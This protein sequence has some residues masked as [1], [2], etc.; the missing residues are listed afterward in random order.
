MKS[1]ITRFLSAG[2]LVTGAALGIHAAGPALGSGPVAEIPVTATA[3]PLNTADRAADRVGRLRFLGAL[4]LTSSD[5]RF[6]GLSDLRWEGKCQRLLAVS[7]TG[8]W[9]V[10]EP[11]LNFFMNLLKIS[12]NILNQRDCLQV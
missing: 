6:G 4:V 2:A 12:N 3:V 9:V 7:D 11:E 8:A 10:L 5:D 1:W